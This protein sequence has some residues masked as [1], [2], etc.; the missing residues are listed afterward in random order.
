[1]CDLTNN[2]IEAEGIRV[3]GINHNRLVRNHNKD[4]CIM[5]EDVLVFKDAQGIIDSI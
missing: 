5:E 2:Y 1:M 3:Y 4:A